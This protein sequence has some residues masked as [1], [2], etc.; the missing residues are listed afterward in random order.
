MNVTRI[1][2]IRPGDHIYFDHIFYEHHAIVEDVDYCREEVALIEYWPADEPHVSS[3]N[4][5][6]KLNKKAKILRRTLQFYD[7]KFYKA[8]HKIQLP[9]REVI[10]RARS[11]IGE[12]AYNLFKNNCEHFA[13]WCKEGDS[14]SKQARNGEMALIGL[15]VTAGVV[16]LGLLI[17][18]IAKASASTQ[19]EDDDDE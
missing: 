4:A 19:E 12:E 14:T 13:N 18:N 8:V 7:E 11:R 16:G 5:I 2:Q 6:S 15:G 1:N 9:A 10:R 17:R 3:S